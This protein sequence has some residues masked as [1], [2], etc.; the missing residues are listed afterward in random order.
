MGATQSSELADRAWLSS[1]LSCFVCARDHCGW[2]TKRRVD[3]V[4]AEPEDQQDLTLSS[5]QRC[6]AVS[7]LA[8]HPTTTSAIVQAM[9]LRPWSTDYPEGKIVMNVAAH[10]LVAD[11]V[12]ARLKKCSAIE[13][14]ELHYPPPAGSMD[15]RKALVAHLNRH[16]LMPAFPDQLGVAKYPL[17]PTNLVAGNGCITMLEH[18]VFCTTDPLDGVL[19]PQP[20]WGAFKIVVGA[21][22]Q[23]VLLPVET[24]ESNG[25]FPTVEQ[26]NSA[27]SNAVSKGV[28]V[29]AMIL[30][31]PANPLG[32]TIPSQKMLSAIQ[33]AVQHGVHVISDEIYGC[34][35]YKADAPPFVSAWDL[36][37]QHLDER[38]AATVHV[39]WSMSKDFGTSGLRVGALLTRNSSVQ[40]CEDLLSAFSMIPA[41]VQNYVSEILNDTAF[42]DS[43]LEDLKE[44]M[45]RT[46]TALTTE[47]SRAG[48]RYLEA[49]SALFLVIDLR[50][51]LRTGATFEDEEDLNEKLCERGVILNAG[52]QFG[53]PEP[54]LFRACP[55]D[56]DPKCFAAF[57]DR[58]ADA[59]FT[60]RP[61]SPVKKK[62]SRSQLLIEVAEI[63]EEAWRS[64]R[65]VNV[66][67]AALHGQSYTNAG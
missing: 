6:Q 3:A 41:P 23:C 16:F 7:K 18:A 29:K 4:D 10:S 66:V 55:F 38:Q 44:A 57:A 14:P 36:A 1:H 27:Y 24:N 63:K 35:N 46:Y 58:I 40:V 61:P 30:T 28:P 32:V 48:V 21:R 5:S 52:A 33:W 12:I 47:L 20:S 51:A 31:N 17:N 59:A 49:S 42:V 9:K 2:A 34:T 50:G 54:G 67:E 11:R 56:A 15:L 62:L 25:Y 64:R 53:M 22:N 13:T 19:V 43:C 26:L 39:V 8:H 60:A 37:A 65:F 45:R